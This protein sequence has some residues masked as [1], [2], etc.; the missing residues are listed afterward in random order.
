MFIT[1]QKNTDYTT[2]SN[3]MVKENAFKMLR[4]RTARNFKTVN[5][6]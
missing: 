1:P 2:I 5:K 4:A 6:K 3:K